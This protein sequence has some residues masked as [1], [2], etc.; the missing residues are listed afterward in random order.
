MHESTVITYSSSDS[1]QAR[2]ELFNIMNNYP[3]TE[4]EKEL[5]LGLFVRGSLLARI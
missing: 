1:I 2:K 4:D 3:A 5:S